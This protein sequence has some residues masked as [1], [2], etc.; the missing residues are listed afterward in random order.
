MSELGSSAIHIQ[1]LSG[2]EV[3][4]FSDT[5]VYDQEYNL[6]KRLNSLVMGI[7]WWKLIASGQAWLAK[8]SAIRKQAVSL[9]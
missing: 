1:H 7:F 2:E 4:D 9:V 5:A 6:Q 8:L 3:S